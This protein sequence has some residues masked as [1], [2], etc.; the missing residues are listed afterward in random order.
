LASYTDIFRTVSLSENIGHKALGIYRILGM[1][2]FYMI[3]Y[4]LRPWRAVRTVANVF[5]EH[6]ESR[7]EMSLRDLFF[8]LYRPSARHA[9]HRA[10]G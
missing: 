1:I 3:S 7:L 5:R 9:G 2:L 8:R 10:A 6:Q 4:G